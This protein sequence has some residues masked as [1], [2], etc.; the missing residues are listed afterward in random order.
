L[1][2]STEGYQYILVAIESLSHFVELTPL[3]TQTATEIAEALLKIWCRY[4][5]PVSLMSDRG[6]ALIGEVIQ[7]LC[8]LFDVKK[9]NTTAYAQFSNSLC[10]L[11]NKTVYTSL[12]ARPSGDQHSW[13]R[14]LPLIAFGHNATIPV[15][16]SNISPAMVMFGRE[17]RLPTDNELLYSADNKPKTYSAQ[18]YNHK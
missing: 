18:E 16:A 17:L 5:P 10:E 13:P 6:P 4:G 1:P 12:K 11:F 15:G 2:L 14:Y 9:V 8:R 7:V 3:K